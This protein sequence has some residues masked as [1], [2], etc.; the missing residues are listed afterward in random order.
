M[1]TMDTKIPGI[2]VP[3]VDYGES[4]DG[5]DGTQVHALSCFALKSQKVRV[6]VDGLKSGSNPSAPTSKHCNINSLMKMDTNVDTNFI[7][8]GDEYLV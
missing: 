8:I 1:D 6:F 5:I 2:L 3:C 4:R 7:V